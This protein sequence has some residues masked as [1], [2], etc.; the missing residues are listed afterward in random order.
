MLVMLVAADGGSLDLKMIEQL[1]GLAGI[2]AG[3]AVS[4][5]Q[6]FERAQSDIAQIANGSCHQIEAWGQNLQPGPRKFVAKN[7]FVV[8]QYNALKNSCG[9]VADC[10]DRDA[11][12]SEVFMDWLE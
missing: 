2:F 1:Q 11:C 6:H 9:C 5:A 7:A 4:L 3:D 8:H 12:L 10:R